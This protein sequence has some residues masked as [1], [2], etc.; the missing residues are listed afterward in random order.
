MNDQ[1]AFDLS[2]GLVAREDGMNRAANNRAELLEIARTLVRKAAL[3]NIHRTA[4]ADDASEGLARIGWSADALGNAAGSLFRGKEWEFTGTWS[5]S[6]RV[7]NHAH[8][9]RVWR[10]V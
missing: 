7:T 2:A 1:L 6:R 9:N 8:Q 5:P 3:K 4:T 10:L